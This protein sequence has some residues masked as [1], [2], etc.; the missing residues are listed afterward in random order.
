MQQG[1]KEE[2]TVWPLGRN[3]AEA[4]EMAEL[5]RARGVR[6]LVGLQARAAPALLYAKALVE[7]G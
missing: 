6:N 5:A 1:S 4:Q 3:T 2:H 7:S